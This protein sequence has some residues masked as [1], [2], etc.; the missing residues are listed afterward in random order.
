M[1]IRVS[2]KDPDVLYEAIREALEVETKSIVGIS[3]KEREAIAE[4][5]ATDISDELV[6]GWVAAGEYFVIEFDTEA[7]TAV[8]V[9]VKRG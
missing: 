6:K 9:P 8:V 4:S 5:R 3:E 7:K 1:K 2:L